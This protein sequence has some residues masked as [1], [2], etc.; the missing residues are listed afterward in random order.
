MP[1]ASR[2]VKNRYLPVVIDLY[3]REVVGYSISKEINAKLAK[4]ALHRLDWAFSGD[5]SVDTYFQRLP[6]DLFL[7]SKNLS[8]SL[9]NSLSCTT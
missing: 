8:K 3:N 9:S 5:D 6:S 4:A 2:F 1:I 7:S